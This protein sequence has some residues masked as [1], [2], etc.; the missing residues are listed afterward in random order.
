LGLLLIAAMESGAAERRGREAGE[1]DRSD[2]AVRSRSGREGGQKEKGDSELED[3]MD[4]M[5]GNFRKLRRQVSDKSQ[6]ASSLTLAAN[7][8][9]LT[10]KAAQLTPRLIAQAPEKDRAAMLASYRDQMQELAATFTDLQ[11]ALKDGK[12][13]KAA[14]IV[15]DLRELE[16]AGHR[17]FRAKDAH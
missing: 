10:Q 13:G 9:R 1:D 3:I 5:N 12:N 4:E 7:L 16:S 11:S 6:S 14:E 8:V 2:A 17:K 15:D